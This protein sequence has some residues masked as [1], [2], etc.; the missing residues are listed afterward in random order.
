MVKNLFWTGGLDSTYR[1]LQLIKDDN[2]DEINLFHISLNIDNKDNYM[3]VVGRISQQKEIETM[4]KILQN[5]D[6]SK[7]KKFTI[8][9]NKSSIVDYTFL[10]P[11]DFVF[12]IQKDFIEYSD[13][14]KISQFD[15]WFNGIV[16]RPI[17]QYGA[18]SQV[19]EDLNI[20]ADICIEKGGGIWSNTNKYFREMKDENPVFDYFHGS[21]LFKRFNLPLYDTDRYDMIKVAKENNWMDILYNTWSCWYPEDGLPCNKCQMCEGRIGLFD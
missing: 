5:I 9:T 1:L 3:F 4:S 6:T 21:I 14:T 19:L 11:F 15:L 8:W 17:N 18:I 16:S 2:V 12:F 7:I 10:L 20:T 13:T